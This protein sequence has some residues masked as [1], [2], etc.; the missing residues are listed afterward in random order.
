MASALTET[1]CVHNKRAGTAPADAV[2]IGRPGPYGNPFVVGVHGTQD[3]CV[4]KFEVYL[5]E[6]PELVAQI[7]RELAGKHLV[8]WCKPKRCHG[9][10]IL[11][12]ANP[13]LRSIQF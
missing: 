5:S 2:Y 13:E 4:D 3:E 7:V 10:I 11:L 6:N 12:T 8:C 9:D 1:P